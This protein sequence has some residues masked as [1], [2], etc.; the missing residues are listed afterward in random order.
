MLIILKLK[1]RNL[2]LKKCYVAIDLH[3]IASLLNK[4]GHG[5]VLN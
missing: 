2:F 4:E 5:K 1:I 3:D